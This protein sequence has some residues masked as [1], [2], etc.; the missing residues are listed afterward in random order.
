MPT[1][2]QI[3]NWL[4][5]QLFAF[6]SFVLRSPDGFNL[7]V[8][9]KV[10]GVDTTIELPEGGGGGNG[11]VIEDEGTPLPQRN[12]LDFRGAGVVASDDAPNNATRVTIPAAPSN[13]GVTTGDSWLWGSGRDGVVHFDGTNTFSFATKTGS[14]YVINRSIH[15]TDCTIDAGVTVTCFDW[16]TVVVGGGNQIFCTGTLTVN[17]HLNN[18]GTNNNINPNIGGLGACNQGGV[19]PFYGSGSNGGGGQIGVGQAGTALTDAFGGVGGAG[20]ASATPNAGGAAGTLTPPDEKMSGGL[21]TLW[22][23]VTMQYGLLRK[24]VTGLNG[25]LNGGTGGGG[26][27]GVPSVA[28][29][30]G[31]GGGGGVFGLF[32]RTL[33]G[34][35]TISC[36]GAPGNNG[37]WQGPGGGGGGG[38]GGGV[39]M[40]IIGILTF[41]GVM[42]ALGGLGGTTNAGGTAG[43]AGQAG[44]VA[45]LRVAVLV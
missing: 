24:N 31:A 9:S 23:I 25:L 16:K 21:N 39:L 3:N 36:D 30:G 6:N 42:R 26:G 38:G 35:G 14:V 8:N 27:G 7:T 28:T 13:A 34:N 37:N 12:F 33:A 17:G 2:Q 4:K 41:T 43:T 40:G 5:R 20:G 19:T 18:D 11:H 32:A 22:T 10:I 29:G 44:V 45:I 15:A 1:N